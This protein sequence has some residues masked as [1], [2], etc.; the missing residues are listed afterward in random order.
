MWGDYLLGNKSNASMIRKYLDSIL[1]KGGPF[2]DP[3]SD[4]GKGTISRLE[5]S[6][7]LSVDHIH[8]NYQVIH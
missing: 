1:T 6:K 8:F 5:E 4:L 2:T 7:I 3:D